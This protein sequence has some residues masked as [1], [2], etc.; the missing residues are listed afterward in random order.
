M[1]SFAELGKETFVSLTTF[2]KTGE[3]VPTAVWAALTGDALVV[4]TRE[5]AGKVKRARNN[6]L[7][8]LVPCSVSGKIDPDAIPVEGSVEV[9]TEPNRIVELMRPLRKKYGLQF[10][11][12]MGSERKPSAGRAILLI[13]PVGEA[14]V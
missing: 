5:A 10:R 1:T 4:I 9:V 6:P 11:V 12:M 2:R 7:V 14:T 13:T 8:E 3:G